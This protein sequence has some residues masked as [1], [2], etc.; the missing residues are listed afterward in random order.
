MVTYLVKMIGTLTNFFI[1]ALISLVSP[2]LETIG[3]LA[4]KHYVGVL[5]LYIRC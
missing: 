1:R 5:L 4:K 2:R 3:V